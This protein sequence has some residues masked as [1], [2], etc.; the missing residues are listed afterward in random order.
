MHPHV[1]SGAPRGPNLEIL[2]EAPGAKNAGDEGHC[3]LKGDCTFTITIKNTG[4]APFTDPI[5]IKDEISPGTPAL[6][7][8]VPVGTARWECDTAKNGPGGIAVNRSINCK[9]TPQAGG[10][11]PGGTSFWRSPS[12]PATPGKGGSKLKNCAKSP[13]LPRTSVRPGS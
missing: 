10:L 7:Q 2:K 13:T 6:I 4:T 12:R 1:R 8:K 5:T 9:M 3:D 11:P